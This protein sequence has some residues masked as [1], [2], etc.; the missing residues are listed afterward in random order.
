M[1][2]IGKLGVALC[3]ATPVF[4]G[5]AKAT[6]QE[7]PIDQNKSLSD[8]ADAIGT[9]NTVEVSA[10]QIEAG[11][12]QYVDDATITAGVKK[13]LVDESAAIAYQVT[14][15][16]VKG[17]VN[18]SGIVNTVEDRNKVVAIT[19]AV[20]GVRSIESDLVLKSETESLADSRKI[21][22]I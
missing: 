9:S 17:S 5:C 20:P 3:I 15:R 18:L 7:S 6:P 22:A 11:A 13:A 21:K 8:G 4:V 12:I 16:T 2:N 14:V 19:K 1:N 10:S